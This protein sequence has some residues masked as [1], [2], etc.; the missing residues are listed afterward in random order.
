MA[1]LG[2][3]EGVERTIDVH[4]HNLRKKLEKDPANPRHILT[5]F[6]AGYRFEFEPIE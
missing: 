4:I 6:G 3:Y 5:A 2:A 1:L